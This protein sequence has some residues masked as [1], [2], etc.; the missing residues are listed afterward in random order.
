MTATTL[1]R[2][3]PSFPPTSAEYPIL[4]PLSNRLHHLASR[5]CSSR[6]NN[7]NC[8]V[9]DM[10]EGDDDTNL[11]SLPSPHSSS[12]AIDREEKC[13]KPRLNHFLAQRQRRLQGI[14]CNDEEKL[15]CRPPF[16]LSRGEYEQPLWS[17][18]IPARM[19][20]IQNWLD[21]L[22][23]PPPPHTLED[24]GGNGLEEETSHADT[25]RSRLGHPIDDDEDDEVSSLIDREEEWKKPRPRRFLVRRSRKQRNVNED[26]RCPFPLNSDCGEGGRPL[27]PGMSPLQMR[28]LQHQLLESCK[29][30]EEEGKEENTD[31]NQE[32]HLFGHRISKANH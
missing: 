2:K 23:P 1:Q 32:D 22:S 28:A 25:N 27:R 17:G 21:S 29:T 26:E 12:L 19:S 7:G 31:A 10:L 16:L 15:Y 13:Q 8:Y 18:A 24:E 6:S 20:N 14:C 11:L 9:S 3:P 5:R 4:P 30:E